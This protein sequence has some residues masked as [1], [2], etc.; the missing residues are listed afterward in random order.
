MENLRPQNESSHRIHEVL[1]N[2]HAALVLCQIVVAEV[3][4]LDCLAALNQIKDLNDL[5]WKERSP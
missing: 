5:L 3:K 1:N 2:V 4:E